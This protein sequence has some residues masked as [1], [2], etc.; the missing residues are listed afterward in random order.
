MPLPRISVITP[1]F[2]QAEFIER[3]IRSVLDQGYAAF[4]HIVVDGG[5]TDGTIDVLKRYPHLRWISE[6]DNGQTHAL[7]KGFR[8]A[9]GEIVGWLNSDDTYN[10]GAF[11]LIGEA[12]SDPGV[13]VVYGDGFET[14]VDDEVLRE[15]RSKNVSFEGLVRYWKWSYEFIQPSFF[16]RR[17]VFD[18]VGYLDE[19]LHYAMDVDFIIRLCTRFDL[20]Y[21]PKPLANLR[22]YNASKTGKAYRKLIPDY[23]WE[24][25][26][27]SYRHWGSPLSPRYWNYAA[28]FGGA[29]T[30]SLVKNILMT[31]GSKSRKRFRGG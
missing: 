21:L 10:A 15:F 7:N 22:L 12:F 23:I 20:R 3:N 4:E 28:S 24:M 18:E 19:G 1:S 14:G 30:L 29:V 8:M 26:K 31:P 5:S 16:F 27:V 11:A 17:T 9:T 25:Q 6:G 13:D 2:N